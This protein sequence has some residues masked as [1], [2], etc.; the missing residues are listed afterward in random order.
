MP[1]TARGRRRKANIKKFNSLSKAQQKPLRHD[2]HRAV[3]YG[4]IAGTFVAPGVGT[5]V[6]ALAG[7]HI[8]QEKVFNKLNNTTK[9]NKKTTKTIT[10]GHKGVARKPTGKKGTTK[11]T[12][13][14]KGARGKKTNYVQ[15]SHGRFA[16][17][18]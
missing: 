7:Q 14:K 13:P 10:K 16:G 17:S 8:G 11:R 12:A 15:D 5:A 1:S 3:A 2:I 6:G 9:K 4:A 18:K